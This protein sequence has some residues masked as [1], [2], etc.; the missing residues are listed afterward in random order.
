MYNAPNNLLPEMLA[1]IIFGGIDRNC[2]LK[3]QQ[4]KINSPQLFDAIL[5][6][7]IIVF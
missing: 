1:F 2:I 5:K 6:S 4:I 3:S 7:Y